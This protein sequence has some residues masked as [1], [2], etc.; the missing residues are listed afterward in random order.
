MDRP[1]Y[2]RGLQLLDRAG[3]V[4]GVAVAVVGIDHQRQPGG[5]VDAVGLTGEFAQGQDDQVRRPQDREGG[6]GTGEHA[7]FESDL[8]GNAR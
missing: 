8:L 3:D 6:D 5:A 7:G 4:E 2:A 1:D